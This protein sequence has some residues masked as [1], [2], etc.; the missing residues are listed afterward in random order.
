M[1]SAR[2][3]ETQR[4]TLAAA[5]RMTTEA[6]A[7]ELARPT[8]VAPDWTDFEWTVARAVA[9]MHGVSPLLSLTLQWDGPA[10]WAEFLE[11][12]RLHTANRHVRIVELL[13]RI[14]RSAR[15]EGIAVVALKGAALHA[16]GVYAAGER[17]MADVDLLVR[18]HDA[19]SAARMITSL[20]YVDSQTTWKEQVFTPIADRTPASL[21]EHSNNN[22]KIELHHRICEMLPRRLTDVSESIF[23]REAWP[24]LN[25]YPSLAS[26]M[27]HLLLHAAGGMAFQTLRLL[28]LHDIALLTAHMTTA[29]WNAVLNSTA[30][31][32][33]W[34]LLPPLQLTSIYYPATVPKRVLK[35]VDE[36][37]PWLL[38][39]VTSRKTLCDVSLSHLWIDAFPGI[40][41]SRSAPDLARYIVGRIRPGVQH[42]AQ[43]DANVRTQA[44]ASQSRWQK[45]SQGRRILRWVMSRQTRAAT[46]YAVNAAIAQT[47]C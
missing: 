20:G 42:L 23:P 25:A 45:L 18:P 43:R 1:R 21:G 4:G 19:R 31:S 9:S 6:L 37:C 22:I 15:R 47:R 24:G 35:V 26:L 32:G 27:T 28:Q 5:L 10:P 40:E 46:M 11:Q 29:D 8:T 39:R 17:P 30:A 13:Q 2:T 3:V 16:L 38:R 7:G 33:H 44:W 12:Q 41:W 34:W 14:D 36:S